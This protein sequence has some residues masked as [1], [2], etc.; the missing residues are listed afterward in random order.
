M[1]LLNTFK[2]SGLTRLGFLMWAQ[3]HNVPKQLINQWATS[4]ENLVWVDLMTIL[5]C[6]YIEN[7]AFLLPKQQ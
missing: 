1:G 5:Q 3:V 6:K 2:K 7:R 4:G